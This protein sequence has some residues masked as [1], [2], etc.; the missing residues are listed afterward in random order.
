MQPLT[1][2]FFFAAH[3]Q[4]MLIAKQ[5]YWMALAQQELAAVAEEWARG[6][7]VGF[8]GGNAQEVVLALGVVTLPGFHQYRFDLSKHNAHLPF[9][10]FVD[11]T[12]R[13]INRK[14]SSL[15]LKRINLIDLKRN[16]CTS[17]TPSYSKRNAA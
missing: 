1:D 2:Q 10:L 8:C 15:T 6:S 11:T 7:S 13:V 17:S 4:A 16:L 14:S 5:A 3:Q 9:S 12:L